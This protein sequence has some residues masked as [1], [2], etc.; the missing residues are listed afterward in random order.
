MLICLGNNI[1][2]LNAHIIIHIMTCAQINVFG[3][4]GV[5]EPPPYFNSGSNQDLELN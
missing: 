5:F 3:V 1:G 4:F 2:S